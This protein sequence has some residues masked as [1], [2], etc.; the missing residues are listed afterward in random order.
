MDVTRSN[1]EEAL[2]LVRE[3]IASAD[4]IAFDW[5]LTGLQVRPL[6]PIPLRLALA[7][8]PPRR[9]ASGDG[10]GLTIF[11]FSHCDP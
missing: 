4:V 11:L 9:S 3:E 5:E 7:P 6:L 2:Q 10:L 1:F 8:H